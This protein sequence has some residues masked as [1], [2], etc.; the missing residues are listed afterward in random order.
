M[1][2]ANAVLTMC[3]G[4]N[5]LMTSSHFTAAG[6][7]GYG[8]VLF[9]LTSGK[10]VARGCMSLPYGSS[11]GRAEFEGLNAGLQAAL[12]AGIGSLAV[13]VHAM[14]WSGIVAA[15][16]DNQ[17][18]KAISGQHQLQ[19]GLHTESGNAYRRGTRADCNIC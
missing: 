18:V 5:C 11:A 15:R 19:R 17:T 2:K 10:M 4:A 7:A 1:L 6:R 12:D 8:Y 13:Q 14:E 9:D 16:T 3:K